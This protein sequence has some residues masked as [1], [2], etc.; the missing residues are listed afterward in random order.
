MNS[1]KK[2][3]VNLISAFLNNKQSDYHDDID[4]YELYRLGNIHNVCGIIA[5]QLMGFSAD[6][7]R[8]IENLP[9]F[10]QQLGY[11]IISYD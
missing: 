9:A 4:Y 10:R 6:D 5:K 8:K 3:F 7:R 1:T 11:T 2:Y